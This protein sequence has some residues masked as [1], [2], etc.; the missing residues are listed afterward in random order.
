MNFIRY[1]LYCGAAAGVTSMAAVMLDSMARGRS[2][3][4]PVNATSHW[5]WG[6]E[7]GWREL[8]DT[9]HT[10]TGAAT[11]QGAAMF[12][13]AIFGAWLASQ[14]RRTTGEMFRDAA[15][16]GA[17]AATL[18]YGILPRRLSPG[19]EL[20]GGGR[21]AAIGMAA[22]AIGLALG[23]LAAQGGPVRPRRRRRVPRQYRTGY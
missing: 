13:G 10:V 6:D 18:D 16:M 23:G 1:A 14:P 19:W 9:A 20:A 17:I 4:Q 7:A 3:W 21:S 11:N 22:T 12:W 8:P 5:I 15:A 2:P